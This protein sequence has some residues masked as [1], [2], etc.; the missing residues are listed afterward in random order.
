MKRHDYEIEEDILKVLLKNEH[1]KALIDDKIFPVYIEEGTE[2]DAVYYDSELDNP[3]TCKMGNV[4]NVM[5]F[6]ACAVSDK[7]DNSNRIIGVIQDILEGEYRDPFMR[8]RAVG[9]AKNGANFKYAKTMD[10][11]IEW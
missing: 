4:T 10:F 3:E 5:H 11:L 9:S 1:L 2:G 6:Y 8:I 7:M